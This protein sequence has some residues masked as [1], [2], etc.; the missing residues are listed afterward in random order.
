MNKSEKIKSNRI[1]I[2]KE[3]LIFSYLLISINIF[4][5]FFYTFIIVDGIGFLISIIYLTL[6][7]SLTILHLEGKLTSLKVKNDGDLYLIASILGY[8]LGVLQFSTFI[9]NPYKDAPWLFISLGWS[10]ISVYNTLIY[11]KLRQI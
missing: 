8:L 11:V 4:G 5:I 7:V 1:D 6:G 10:V 3:K 2:K 9:V